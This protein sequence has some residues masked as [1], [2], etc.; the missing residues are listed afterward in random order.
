MRYTIAPGHCIL[1]DGQPFLTLSHLD[2]NGNNITDKRTTEYICTM[3]NAG[4]QI[5]EATKG[6]LA[7]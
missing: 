1:R 4:E 6:Y 7:K 5:S 2:P 3:L